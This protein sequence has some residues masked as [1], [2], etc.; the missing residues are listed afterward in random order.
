MSTDTVLMYSDTVRSP[1]LRYVIPHSVAD[2]F[3]YVE[4]D[5]HKRVVVRS[6]EVERMTE[7]AGRRAAPGRG[8]R[9]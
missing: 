4:H 3:L 9:A 6:L 1:D 8:V 5:G 2:P 7:V